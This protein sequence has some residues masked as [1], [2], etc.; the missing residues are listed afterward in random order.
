MRL[1]THRH[2]L[3]SPQ[4]RRGQWNVLSFG[5]VLIGSCE[6]LVALPGAFFDGGAV[7]QE[8]TVD[9]GEEEDAYSIEVDV[10]NLKTKV[11]FSLKHKI[12]FFDITVFCLHWKSV[13]S[14]IDRRK[15]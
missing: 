1:S 13:F 5:R 11:F 12:L 7:S 3:L 8:E 6:F 15:I 4:V 10:E 2:L 9:I 14:P